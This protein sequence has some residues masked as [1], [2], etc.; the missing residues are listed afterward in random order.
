MNY[1]SYFASVLANTDL[2]SWSD[3]LLPKEAELDG[4]Q[5]GNFD[6]WL[7]VLERLPSINT[8]FSQLNKSQIIIQRFV[9]FTGKP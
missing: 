4:V 5:Q 8:T 2:H 3:Y 9:G 1:A 7:Q 6:T